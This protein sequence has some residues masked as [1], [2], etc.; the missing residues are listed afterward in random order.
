M[1]FKDRTAILTGAASGMGLLASQL[2][3][4]EGARVV[5]T[6]VSEDAVIREFRD[7]GAARMVHGHTHRP[8]THRHEIDGRACERY[9]LSDWRDRATWLEIGPAGVRPCELAG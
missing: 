2:L 3:A 9:V 1:R 7:A 8:A 6:D 5:M 4:E